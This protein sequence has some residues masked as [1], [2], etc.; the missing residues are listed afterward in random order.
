MF[1]WRWLFSE[2]PTGTV[3]RV[4]VDQVFTSPGW[5]SEGGLAESQRNGVS[6]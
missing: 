1:P 3:H 4:W 6:D 5:L 2:S